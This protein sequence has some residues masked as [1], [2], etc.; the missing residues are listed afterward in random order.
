MTVSY[1]VFVISDSCPNPLQLS[2]GQML[3]LSHDNKKLCPQIAALKTTDDVV[4][5][6]IKFL[7]R[8]LCSYH[9]WQRPHTQE[10]IEELNVIQ[11]QGQ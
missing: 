10:I 8:N 7:I 5:L 2:Y 1:I 9:S 4:M 3:R 6:R 11:Q